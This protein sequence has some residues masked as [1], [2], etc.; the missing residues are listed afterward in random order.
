VWTTDKEGPG[1]GAGSS[2]VWAARVASP[3][4]AKGGIRAQVSSPLF[5]LFF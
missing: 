4:G 2:G 3:G 1:V 5:I